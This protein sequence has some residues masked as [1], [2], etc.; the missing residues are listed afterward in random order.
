MRAITS[1]E[2]KILEQFASSIGIPTRILMEIAGMKIANTAL[3]EFKKIRKA[4]VICGS[5]GNGG[6]GFVAARHLNSS[7]VKTDIFLIAPESKISSQD[8][9]AN[10][11]ILKKLG[12]NINEL[13]SS[14]SLLLLRHSLLETDI[15][16]D[17]IFGI[18]FAGELKES[19]NNIIDLVNSTKSQIKDKRPYAVLSV[20][21][22]SGANAT[23]GEVSSHCIEADITM[24]FEYP[25][26]GLFMHPANKYAGKIITTGIGIPKPN[27]IEKS[28]YFPQETI[29][30]TEDNIAGLSITDPKFVA[31]ILPKRK[32]DFHK[33]NCGKILVIAGSSGMIGAAVLTATSAL[34]TGSGLVT[35]C[36]PNDLK[37][38]VNSMS[39]ETIVAGF[40]DIEILLNDCD[41][42]AIGPGLSKG[43]DISK[44]INNIILSDKI[45][46]P[47]VIDADG[48]NAIS[49][50]D[51]LKRSHH[52]L[53]ITPHPG[54]FSRLINKP[55][56][57]I[58]R[59]RTGFAS[60]FAVEYGV[61]I[62][63]KGAY[64]VIAGKD[65]QIFINP[66]GNPAMASAG[67][68]DVLTGI[69]TSLIGQGA[70][71]F[72]SAVAGAFI[73]GMAGNLAASI[74]G[75]H[76]IIASDIIDSIPFTLSSIL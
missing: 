8:S 59:D 60:R 36:V 11:H 54:E 18:G 2:M 28:A 44:T 65:K 75:E 19:I 38:L 62:V 35:L 14:E 37:D 74:K 12:I 33:G 56:Y 53:I 48:I 4:C 61:T 15:V 49:D 68:G 9:Q 63:L 76:G 46:V 69:I 40:K 55:I 64:T 58:Q 23:T 26:I 6:D 51:I 73:H 45:K 25:K 3:H 66:I 57:E 50:P 30:S 5:G 34:R 29:K 72:N 13:T 10:L 71:S 32:V 41:A 31:G 67:M 17:A 70:S 16:I 27:P 42:I 22:P 20:D 21:V 24:T 47:I 7:G 52:D 39:L 1:E 43:K